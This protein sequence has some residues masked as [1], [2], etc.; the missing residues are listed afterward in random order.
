MWKTEIIAFFIKNAI[1]KERNT[2]TSGILVELDNTK[3]QQLPVETL[4][5]YG[6]TQ[7][8]DSVYQ[9]ALLLILRGLRHSLPT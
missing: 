2:I 4:A 8:H 5:L 1:M 3:L 9:A 6:I 7:D